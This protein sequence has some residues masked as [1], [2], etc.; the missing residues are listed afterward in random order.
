MSQLKP[1]ENLKN[2][3]TEGEEIILTDKA[4]KNINEILG[5]K[6]EKSKDNK[7]NILFKIKKFFLKIDSFFFSRKS[8][9]WNSQYHKR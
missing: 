8:R 3:L 7:D 2:I 5:I 4:Q 1:Y 6:E 9:K